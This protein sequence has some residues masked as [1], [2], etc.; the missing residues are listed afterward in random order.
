MIITAMKQALEALECNVQHKYPLDRDGAIRKGEAAITA[1]HQAIEQAERIE[2]PDWIEVDKRVEVDRAKEYYKAAVTAG[3]V[4]DLKS[5]EFV[6]TLSDGDD[7][8]ECVFCSAPSTAQPTKEMY[9]AAQKVWSD[10][11]YVKSV[12]FDLIYNAMLSAAPAQPANAIGCT[13]SVC[14]DW[15]RWTPSGMVCKNGHGGAPGINHRL[16]THQPE[17][18]EERIIEETARKMARDK[19]SHYRQVMGSAVEKGSYTAVFGHLNMTPDELGN[20]YNA[21]QTAAMLG[22]DA[23]KWCGPHEPGELEDTAI[24]LLEEALK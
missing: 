10:A 11:G 17:H 22:L 6:R 3:V 1:L 12:P 15:Q 19:F 9:A 16:Y 20:R 24:Q 21:L 8:C 5:I 2:P 18:P 4:G 14:G 23:L 13:C 7:L